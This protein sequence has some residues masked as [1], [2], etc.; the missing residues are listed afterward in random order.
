MLLGA[1]NAPCLHLGHTAVHTCKH[2][3]SCHL[4]FLHFTICK[5]YTNKEVNNK[6]KSKNIKIKVAKGEEVA[7]SSLNFLS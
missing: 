5:L 3:V 2:P 7:Q 1:G 6:V 4:Q